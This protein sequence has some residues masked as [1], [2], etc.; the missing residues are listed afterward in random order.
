MPH[1]PRDLT[2]DVLAKARR[3]VQETQKRIQHRVARNA[4]PGA[5]AQEQRALLKSSAAHLIA[6]YRVARQNDGGDTPGL[7]HVRS[8]TDRQILEMA[9]G[10]DPYAS[11][12]TRLLMEV[13]KR[14]SNGV[15]TLAIPTLQDRA[16]E[17]L[18]HLVL[19][20]E[21]EVEFDD[22]LEAFRPGRGYHHA[23][24]RIVDALLRFGPCHAAVLDIQD[25]FPSLDHELVAWAERAREGTG[26]SISGPFS[27]LPAPST[28]KI[29]R[30]PTP[31]WRKEEASRRCLATSP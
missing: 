17:C 19:S 4:S 10:L 24:T 21:W 30:C 22:C 18:H 3:Y 9:D 7:D 12:G 8:L 16:V 28:S 27:R 23:L 29:S 5:I 6:V 26:L 13:P 15:R 20:P 2:E 31:A 11:P 1:T 14:S 25:F